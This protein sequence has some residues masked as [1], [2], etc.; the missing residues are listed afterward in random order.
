M[1]YINLNIIFFLLIVAS[2]WN[3]TQLVAQENLTLSEIDRLSYDYFNQKKWDELID[4]GKQS[5]KN[6]IDFYYLQY[7]LG[8]AYYNKRNYRKAIPHF[9]TVVNITPEDAIAKEY[10]YYS[11][12]FGLQVEDARNILESLD[13]QHR[14]KVSFYNQTNIFNGISLNYKNI[15]FDDYAINNTVVDNLTQVTR[16]SLS[17]YSVNLFN[18]AEKSSIFN[19]NVSL[20]SGKNSIYDIAYSPE[21]IDEKMNQY[22]LYFSWNK[23]IGKGTNLKFGLTY[24][25]E[26]LDWFG[27][28]QTTT[29][30]NGI[31]PNKTLIYD[32]TFSNFASFV[33]FS[34]TIKNVDFTLASSFSRI[35]SNSLMQPS[36]SISYFP[37]GNAS[38]YTKTD[39]FYQHNFTY[40]N[41]KNIVIKQ[42]INSTISPNFSINIFGMY[43][44]ILNF[45]DDD[46][47]AIYNNLDVLNYWYGASANYYFSNKVQLYVILRNDGLINQY[48]QDNIIIDNPYNTRSILIGMQFN[49]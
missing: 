11:Y 21:I 2:V 27:L 49:F 43:G 28:Q 38:F 33:S 15:A 36:I 20:L 14:E 6:D 22:Q 4:L 12:L 29:T 40:Q 1:K 47:M 39:V 46:G 44:E 30:G 37:S 35:N 31:S 32:G 34:K 23:H 5:L 13:T 48:T 9:E 26:T 17:Y 10:L 19:F 45:V 24:M 3:S 25:S 16:N 18:Y 8:I 41:D 42:S 7:R